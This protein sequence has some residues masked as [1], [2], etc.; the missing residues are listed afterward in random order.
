MHP[1]RGARGRHGGQPPAARKR[2]CCP[3][4]WARSCANS[5]SRSPGCNVRGMAGLTTMLPSF[6]HRPG[7]ASGPWPLAPS[8]GP[9]SRAGPAIP[10]RGRPLRRPG[11]AEEAE[12]GQRAQGGGAGA[13]E[14]HRAGDEERGSGPRDEVVGCV[15]CGGYGDQRS[16][17]GEP[18]CLDHSQVSSSPASSARS[19]SSSS[20]LRSETNRAKMLLRSSPRSSSACMRRAWRPEL[21]ATGV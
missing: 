16:Q 15:P 17:Q 3:E 13:R 4:R 8:T 1:G 11:S 10:G 9:A 5:A 19:I 18:Y 2:W 7:S 6:P 14:Q 20:G 12:Q 21:S